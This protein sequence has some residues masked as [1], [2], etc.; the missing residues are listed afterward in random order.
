MHE[1]GRN[2][3]V[4]Y[5]PRGGQTLVG[6][7]GLDNIQGHVRMNTEVA[8]ALIDEVNINAQKRTCFLPHSSAVAWLCVGI[9]LKR[10]PYL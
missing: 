5:F 7:H 9:T 10:P 8:M 1:A 4:I 2:A 3:A 6:Q